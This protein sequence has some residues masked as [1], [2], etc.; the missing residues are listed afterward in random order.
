M[1]IKWYMNHQDWIDRVR[2]GEY[3]KWIEKNYRLR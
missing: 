3:N 1:T 2:S